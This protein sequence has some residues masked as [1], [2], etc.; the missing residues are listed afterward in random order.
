MAWAIVVATVLV[1]TVASRG[2]RLVALIMCAIALLGIGAVMAFSWLGQL[3][4]HSRIAPSELAFENVT[5]E[6]SYGDYSLKG[7]VVNHSDH[8]ALESVEVLVTMNDCPSMVY[9]RDCVA[10]GQDNTYIFANV[11][12]GQAR[13]FSDPVIFSEPLDPKGRLVWNYSI[14][15][16]TAH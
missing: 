9:S 15:Q 3:A 4:S 2:F 10:I 5:L 13:D 6:P 8:Y 7:R 11:P 14:S 16:I 12:P 1:L